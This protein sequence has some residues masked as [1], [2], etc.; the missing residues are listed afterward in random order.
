MKVEELGYKYVTTKSI[1]IMEIKK[2]AEDGFFWISDYSGIDIMS[3]AEKIQEGNYSFSGCL[4]DFEFHRKVEKAIRYYL[5]GDFN[6]AVEEIY[7]FILFCFNN[8]NHIKN[9]DDVKKITKCFQSSIPFLENVAIIRKEWEKEWKEELKSLGFEQS[10]GEFDNR[11]LNL[12]NNSID[13][14]NLHLYCYKKGNQLKSTSNLIIYKVIVASDNINDFLSFKN[15]TDCWTV[16]I[17]MFIEKF[18][19]LSYFIITLS[20]GDFVYILTDKP[21]YKFID[22]M[23]A[24]G[25]RNGGRRFSEKREDALNFMPY[26]LIDEIIKKREETKSISKNAGQEIYTFGFEHYFGWNIYYL[27]KYAIMRILSMKDGITALKT[28][29]QLAIGSGD[30]NIDL[31]DTSQFSKIGDDD[32]KNILNELR[33]D[34]DKASTSLVIQKKSI[35]GDIQRY[36]KGSALMTQKQ[37]ENTCIYLAHK[38]I[39]E[40][41]KND[42]I[43]KL[44]LNSEL[45]NFQVEIR[46]KFI[47]QKKELVSIIQ[48]K[49]DRLIPIIFSGLN[50]CLYD[51]DNP[52]INTSCSDRLSKRRLPDTKYLPLVFVKTPSEYQYS[53]DTVG[54][55]E[56]YYTN[57]IKCNERYAKEIEHYREISFLRYT[58]IYTILG[59]RRSELPSLFQNYLSYWFLPYIGNTI[60]DNVLPEYKEIENDFVSKECKQGVFVSI[61]FC[62]YCKRSLFSKYKIAENTVVVISSKQ[63]KIIEIK[64]ALSFDYNDYNKNCEL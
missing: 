37:F 1:L 28:L 51:I 62:G 4:S 9:V 2:L 35:A 17:G 14:D 58:E 30:S 38:K 18:I 56:K 6:C 45:P 27:I 7:H 26:R 53:W 24:Y 13:T 61:P 48:K 42:K 34:E 54:K 46:K 55:K 15:E 59:I 31:S 21:E 33:N 52:F 32:L 39:A 5:S 41:W 63:N 25:S 57:C 49:M 16:R 50:V 47:E 19:D 11:T 40:D 60:L 44:G 10:I 36:Q 43:Q 64:D 29:N 23:E 8:L 12:I 20:Q 3:V 22:Q